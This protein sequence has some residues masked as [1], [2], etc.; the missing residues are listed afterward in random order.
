M[1]EQL[2]AKK[3][4]IASKKPEPPK[5]K[6]EKK[7]PVAAPKKKKPAPAPKKAAPKKAAPS[8]SGTSGPSRK[9]QQVLKK[10]STVKPKIN[11]VTK[12]PYAKKTA[13]GYVAKGAVHVDNIVPKKKKAKAT[14][15]LVDEDY[16]NYW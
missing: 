4:T 1:T 12:Q 10:K 16:M 6:P 14:G 2:D 13:G 5:V 7:Q 11:P 9:R 8:G 15:K 3:P